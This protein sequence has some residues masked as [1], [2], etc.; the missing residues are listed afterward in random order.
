[1]ETLYDTASVA[2]LLSLRRETVYR[3][4]KS[5]EIP[6]IRVGGALR[7]PSSLLKK[8]IEEKAGGSTERWRNH[9]NHF[10]T[11][12]EKK[13]GPHLK[14]VV[15]F[16]SRASKKATPMSDID[17]LIVSD[18]FSKSRL[19]RQVTLFSLAKELNPSFAHRLSP[20]P[21]TPQEAE[22]PKPLYLGLLEAYEILYDADGFSQNLLEDFREKL[23]QTGAER[24]TTDDGSAY[25][26]FPRA[27][28]YP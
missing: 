14:S 9:L 8:W 12:L 1:M 22:E 26:T 3:K 28:G 2:R 7:F 18:L 10:V 19:E 23:K 20:L 27:E 24:K 17:L 5:G 21:L 6:A 13:W 16:G 15:L 25:W 11:L 4:V